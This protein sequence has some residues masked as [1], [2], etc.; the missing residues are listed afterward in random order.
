[1]FKTTYNKFLKGSSPLDA[2]PVQSSLKKGAASLPLL[3]NL[4]LEYSSGRS[5]EIRKDWYRMEHF[6]SWSFSS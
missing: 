2:F 4:T 3:F 1:V 6:S 5:K